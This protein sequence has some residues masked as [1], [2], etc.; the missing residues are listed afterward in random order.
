[1]LRA[2]LE[3]L[4]NVMLSEAKH[5]AIETETLRFA[6]GGKRERVMNV[7]IDAFGKSRLLSFDRDLQTRGPTVEVAHEALLR[8]WP[9]L[10]EWLDDSRA[11]V[12]MQRQLANAAVEWQVANRDISFLLTGAHLG[13]FEGWALS[14]SV[15]LTGDERAYLDASLAEREQQEAI[16]RE[17]QRRELEAAH[18]LAESERQR[19]EAQ[20]QAANRLRTRNRVIT[21]VGVVALVLAVIALVFG[22]QSNQNA[23]RADQNAAQAQAE[24]IRADQQRDAAVNAQAT[25][26]AEAQIRATQQAV[27]EAN[28]RQAEA[29]RLA[30]EAN[31]L[32]LSEGNPEQIALL[33]LRSMDTQYSPQGDAALVAAARLDYPRQFFV[34]HSSSIQSV[35]FSPDGK[36][37]LTGSEDKTA[38]LWDI[39]TGQEVRQFVGH[40]ELIYS[41]IFSPDGRYVGTASWDETARLWDV[42]TGEEIRRFIAYPSYS[43]G[44]AYSPDGKVVLTGSADGIPRLWDAATGQELHKFARPTDL[45][46]TSIASGAFSPDG[47]YVLTGEGSGIARLWDIQTNQQVR[48]FIGHTNIVATVVLTPDWKLILYGRYLLKARQCEVATGKQFGR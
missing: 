30:A 13:Q 44:L 39:Q 15:A 41:A 47:K 18:K 1:V 43:G 6:Q 22:A 25:A 10:R 23:A 28:F 26:V 46:T 42:R 8:E 32:L 12:R 16:E 2:E 31:K 3:S 33:S 4:V 11:D 24:S 38:R 17:R 35:A 48:Q 7:V 20:A 40:T 36:Y 19:A 45:I 21:A 37:A 14:T 34:G 5:P 9:R 29:Q 27:A